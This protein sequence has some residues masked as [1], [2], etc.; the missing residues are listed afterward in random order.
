[1]Y[2]TVPQAVEVSWTMGC[3]KGHGSESRSGQFSANTYS[4]TS[5][6]PL[7]LKAAWTFK[8]LVIP[9][10]RSDSCVVSAEAQLSRSGALRLAIFGLRRS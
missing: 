6:G 10:P 2:T 5:G 4:D 8:S 1:V 7:R 9:V 3:S